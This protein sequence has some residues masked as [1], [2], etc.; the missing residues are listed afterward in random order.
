MGNAEQLMIRLELMSENICARWHLDNYVGRAIVSYNCSATEYVHDDFVDFKE[1]E[2][3]VANEHVVPDR[4]TICSAG[5]GSILFI[6]GKLYPNQ[7]NS[8]VHKA[9][10]KLYY[11]DGSVATRLILKID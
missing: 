9:P 4:E 5:V 8:L 1:F 10:D 3:R 6:K 11:Q 7:I 2:N